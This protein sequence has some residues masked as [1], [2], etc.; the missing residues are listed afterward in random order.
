MRNWRFW[1]WLTALLLA[2]ATFARPSLTLP[3]AVHRYVFVLDI[4]QSMNAR[5]YHV[6]DSPSD[7]LGY[8]KAVLEQA[9][10]Q[11][12]CGSEAGLAVFTHKN[13]HLLLTPLEI[14]QHGAALRD[15]LRAIDW[16]SAW[17]A[18][19]YVAY[20]LFDA[21]RTAKN[22]DAAVVFFSDGQQSPETAREPAFN[23]K[24]GSVPGWVMGVGGTTPIPIPKLDREGRPVGFWQTTDLTRQVLTQR[25]RQ[26]PPHHRSGLLLSH[27]DE[28]RLRQL[29]NETGLGYRRL[30]TIENL[31]AALIDPRTA[32]TRSVAT[33]LRPWL[34]WLILGLAATVLI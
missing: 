32:Q 1:V 22:L 13:T 20:G 26:N 17:A 19:S 14:C 10:F 8:T 15:T 23:G 2:A 18:D 24:P 25:Y 3:R 29:A 34:G 27:L 7:R 9:L 6:T 30:T 5:D 31:T 4:T 33:D 12:P 11:L 21:I 28:A 16:R